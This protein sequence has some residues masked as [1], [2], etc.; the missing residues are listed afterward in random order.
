MRPSLTQ[1]QQ[2]C[3]WTRAGDSRA[4][5]GAILGAAP[6]PLG[7]WNLPSHLTCL[8]PSPELSP[9]RQ[10]AHQLTREASCVQRVPGQHF[11]VQLSVQANEV[12]T[13]HAPPW[14]LASHNEPSHFTA[15]QGRQISPPSP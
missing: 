5:G 13:R 12:W 14:G 15:P 2:L 3:V 4:L 10:Q 7:L 1:A 6:S 9:S 8:R 11:I